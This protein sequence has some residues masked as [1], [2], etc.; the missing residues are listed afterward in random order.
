MRSNDD[1]LTEKKVREW[2]GKARIKKLNIFDDR[3]DIIRRLCNA[4]LVSWGKDPDQ[5]R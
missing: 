5:K 3:T 4:L 1:E 2:L